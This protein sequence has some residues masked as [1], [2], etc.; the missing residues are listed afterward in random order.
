MG[1]EENQRI[2]IEVSSFQEQALTPA[3]LEKMWIENRMEGCQYMV[4]F[5]Q[6]LK[7]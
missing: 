6:Y 5:L 3:I 7:T 4:K 1:K 2:P